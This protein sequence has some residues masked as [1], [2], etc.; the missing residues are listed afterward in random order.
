[1]IKKTG[2]GREILLSSVA[3]FLENKIPQKTPQNMAGSVA[4][5][6]TVLRL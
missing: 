1:M 4:L 6:R 5:Q 3:G 2:H